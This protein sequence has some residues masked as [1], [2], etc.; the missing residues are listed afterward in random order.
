M[1]ISRIAIIL[2]ICLPFWL[3]ASDGI[4]T[5]QSLFDQLKQ[6]DVLLAELEVD[7]DELESHRKT[8]DYLA[9]RFS[10]TPGDGVTQNWNVKVRTRGR[11]RRKIC[12][13]PPLRLRFSKKELSAKGL[14]KHN[15]FKLVTHCLEGEEGDDLIFREYLTYELYNLLT[16]NSLRTQLVKITYKDTKSQKKNTQYGILIEDTDQMAER[17]DGTICKECYNMEENLFER[18]NI[19]LHAVFQY[20]IG[21]TDWSLRMA[22]NLKLVTSNQ[23]G[24]IVVIPY[25]FDF[26]GLVNAS[27]AIPNPDYALRSVRQR[28]FL[29]RDINNDEMATTIQYF[30]ARRSDLLDYVNSF[31]LLSKGSRKD[32]VRYLE[33]F[34]KEL[35]TA[36][37][38]F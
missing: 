30:Q 21:N 18:D 26:S 12:D 10:F 7:F 14:Q 3:S 33:T 5:S 25:D 32:I 13:I 2:I 35:R 28:H 31:E 37:G 19:R 36:E 15:A 20:M 16:D 29:G 24:K 34:F 1:K 8:N 17:L 23:S 27:Y 6:E 22:R 4:K 9:A 11:F 38:R